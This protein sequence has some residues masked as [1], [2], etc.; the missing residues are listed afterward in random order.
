M[1]EA[2]ESRGSDSAGQLIGELFKGRLS[3]AT[4]S[5]SIIKIFEGQGLS[6]EEIYQRIIDQQ[7]VFS[8]ANEALP[9]VQGVRWDNFVIC[10][11]HSLGI[12]EEERMR[13]RLVP[14][15]TPSVRDDFEDL[16]F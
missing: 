11:G 12:P 15:G 3:P 4:A 5:S 8:D 16:A 10:L 2:I 1:R 13:E 7:N 14:V 6:R 9:Q